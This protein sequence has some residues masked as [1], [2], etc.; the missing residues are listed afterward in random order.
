MPMP[1]RDVTGEKFGY[2]KAIRRT[3]ALGEK[4]TVW[5]WKCTA[6]SC[7]TG[8][9]ERSLS[10]VIASIRRGCVIT[11]CASCAATFT[12]WRLGQ[13]L[14]KRKCQSCNEYFIPK[15]LGQVNH[16]K[17]CGRQFYRK[18]KH[19]KWVAARPAW[20]ECCN[21]EHDRC[22][23]GVSKWFPP[24]SKCLNAPVYCTPKCHDFVRNNRY[25]IDLIYRGRQS[26]THMDPTLTIN[27]RTLTSRLLEKYK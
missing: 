13:N 27:E 7:T 17:R 18:R 1:M 11:A 6:P 14:R 3:S 20:V 22:W 26:L 23:P 8:E 16:S 12:Q 25:H 21:P 10:S 19:D 15:T 5:L 2:L 4:P 9:F 24:K